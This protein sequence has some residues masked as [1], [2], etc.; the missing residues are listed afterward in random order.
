MHLLLTESSAHPGMLA[1]AEA[2][3]EYWL[4]LQKAAVKAPSEIDV[5]T[6]HDALGLMYPLNWST[7]ENG[8]WE[9]FMLQEMVCGDVTEIYARYGA[10]YFRLRDVC[11]L[12]HA[13]ITTR[14]KEGF[15][16]TEK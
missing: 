9:T 16:L 3:R 6:F 12:S 13:Q 15:N 5:H 4:S 10:R 11:N 14:I 8:E 2:E 7:S 1:T